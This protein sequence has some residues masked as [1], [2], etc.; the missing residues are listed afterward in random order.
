[1]YPAHLYPQP[2]MYSVL[3]GLVTVRSRF[4]WTMPKLLLA[5]VLVVIGF[6]VLKHFGTPDYELPYHNSTQDNARFRSI[7]EP[8]ASS[9][10]P[11][12]EWREWQ[13]APPLRPLRQY[14]PERPDLTD[15][16][17]STG[18]STAGNGSNTNAFIP[19]RFRRKR[20]TRKQKARLIRAYR[21]QCALCRKSLQSFDTEFD[22]I[23]ALASD[24]FGL[25]H[26]SLNSPDNYRP[27]CR[28][29][30]GWVTWKQ[31]KAGLFKRP[32]TT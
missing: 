28:R 21:G 27:L 3:P 11:R 26:H 6:L 14:R 23:E 19:T 30:H 20:L 9:H 17:V 22:H 5:A 24:P 18:R 25:R 13:S 31:R 8:S 4:H 15:E 1:M 10:P 7:V 29:C 16:R 2:Q 12:R 32:T